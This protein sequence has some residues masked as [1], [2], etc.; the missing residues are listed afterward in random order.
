[1]NDTVPSS[2]SSSS[3]KTGKSQVA[4]ISKTAARSERHGRNIAAEDSYRDASIGMEVA[5]RQPISTSVEGQ[6]DDAPEPSSDGLPP[7]IHK[8]C[9]PT[10]TRQKI[11]SSS[12][13]HLNS[14]DARGS[15]IHTKVLVLPKAVPPA[16]LRLPPSPSASNINQRDPGQASSKFLPIAPR[17][18]EKPNDS[19]ES[20]TAIPPTA[21]TVTTEK[22][23]R[24]QQA[25]FQALKHPNDLLYPYKV[26]KIPKVA[27]VQQDFKT[28]KHPIRKTE[29]LPM[30]VLFGRGGITNAHKGN[31]I[32]RNIVANYRLW[33]CT[34]L[35]GDK[36]LL[37]N[38]LV[39]Y[40]RLC[41]SRFLVQVDGDPHWYEAGDDKV[42]AKCSQTL[43]EGMAATVRKTLLQHSDSPNHHN[44]KL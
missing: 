5:R 8:L 19:K 6:F 22:S 31:Q 11:S 43:R 42:R 17:P 32:F 14:V 15:R 13:H 4:V 1:M 9:S 30:D 39:R 16:D 20:T 36:S 29:I 3:K 37:A 18:Q 23:K 7:P 34:V 21:D 10:T 41:G 25:Y 24:Y 38:N 44:V 33:Y 2:A 40:F 27:P 12:N 28:R 35:K 26:T